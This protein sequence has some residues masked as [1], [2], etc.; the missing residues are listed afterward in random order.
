MRWKQKAMFMKACASLPNGAAIYRFA[1][2]KFG[3]LTSNPA[4][5]IPD[6]IKLARWLLEEGFD[7]EG[8]VFLEV[9]LLRES[10]LHLTENRS[11]LEPMYVGLAASPALNERLNVM[12]QLR[13]APQDF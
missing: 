5:R 3:R 12:H 11:E 4:A 2:K 10:L 8:R 1:Q 13:R 9:G 6:Q 7:I